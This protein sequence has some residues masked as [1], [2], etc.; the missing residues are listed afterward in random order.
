RHDVGASAAGCGQGRVE[1]LE[2]QPGL[3]LD[4]SRE[5]V[6]DLR[7]V[8][9]VVVDGGGGD[10]RYENEPSGMDLDR[11]DVG[12]EDG[13]VVVRVVN[14]LEAIPLNGAHRLQ[15]PLVYCSTNSRATS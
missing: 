6:E 4:V 3:A 9:V 12:R 14:H 7:P 5:C 11:R 10:A 2:E 15:P 1:V 8:R 13:R